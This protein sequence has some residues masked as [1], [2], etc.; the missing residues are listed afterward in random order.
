VIVAKNAHANA[1]AP[2]EKSALVDPTA[3]AVADVRSKL[4]TRFKAGFY[5]VSG[6]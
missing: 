4:K 1:D 5:F 2:K 6:H 3:H